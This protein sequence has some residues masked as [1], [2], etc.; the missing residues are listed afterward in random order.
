MFPN[1]SS[2]IIRSSDGNICFKKSNVVNLG[3]LQLR[4]TAIQN[5]CASVIGLSVCP[6]AFFSFS[7]IK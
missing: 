6:I 2:S 5:S 7:F 4:C 1:R 3:D